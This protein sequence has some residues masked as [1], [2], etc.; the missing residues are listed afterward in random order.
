MTKSEKVEKAVS[1]IRCNKL[2]ISEAASKYNLK[3]IHL[4]KVVNGNR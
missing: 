2:T 4:I 1:E 3:L